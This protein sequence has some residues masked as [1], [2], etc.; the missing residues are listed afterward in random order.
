VLHGH[1]DEQPT[2]ATVDLSKL[3][4]EQDDESVCT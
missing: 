2:V 4:L 3:D 1:P